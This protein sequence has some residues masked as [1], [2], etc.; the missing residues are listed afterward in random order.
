MIQMQTN[1][2][3]ADNSGARRVQCINHHVTGQRCDSFA[4]HWI[5]LI[6]HC[7][8]SNLCLLKRF[9][10]L[11]QMLKETDII[12]HLMGTCCD[13]CKYIHNPGIYLT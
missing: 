3:V 7:R 6:C 1:L 2:D 8:R 12:G 10:N 4:S 9:F 13:T 5:S 11:F